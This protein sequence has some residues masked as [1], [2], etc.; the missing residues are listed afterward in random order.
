MSEATV[1]QPTPSG[2][3]PEIAPLVCADIMARS[4]VGVKKYGEPLKA[5]NGRD[6]LVD[7]YQELLDGAQYI[8]QVIE[9]RKKVPAGG[10]EWTVY[11]TK[12]RMNPSFDKP[13]PHIECEEIRV[14]EEVDTPP[15]GRE[16]ILEQALVAAKGVI[17][18][19][20]K[21]LAATPVEGGL[22]APGAVNARR[23]DAEYRF[24]HLEDFIAQAECHWPTYGGTP[25]AIRTAKTNL[26]CLKR[27]FEKSLSTP[28]ITT[29]SAGPD[30]VGALEDDIEH[31]RREIYLADKP[32]TAALERIA[33]IARATLKGESHHEA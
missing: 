13:Y 19:L 9:E 25:D 17:S 24:R 33:T 14:R 7:L 2:K 23:D 18:C 28:E 3:G 6:P 29:P 30:V 20:E 22:A 21:R 5:F 1:E 12:H 4:A 27:A 26:F 32:A 15:E 16:V 31:V 10:R 11:K 8:R